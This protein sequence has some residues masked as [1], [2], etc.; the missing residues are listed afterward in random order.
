MT[1]HRTGL[2]RNGLF[3]MV[4]EVYRFLIMWRQDLLRLIWPFV[5]LEFIYLWAR[6]IAFSGPIHD[7]VSLIS[8]G[9]LFLALMTLVPLAARVQ[10]FALAPGAVDSWVQFASLPRNRLW[11]RTFVA[12]CLPLVLAVL[13][14]TGLMILISNP[15]T[16]GVTRTNMSIGV[17]LSIV[18]SVLAVRLILVFPLAFDKGRAVLADAWRLSKG[19]YF[20]LFMLSGFATVPFRLLYRLCDMVGQEV[21]ANTG[22]PVASKLAFYFFAVFLPSTVAI[23][24]QILVL[25]VAVTFVYRDVT[26]R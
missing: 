26:R 2:D 17:G 6:F 1:G 14:G 13:V 7:E 3:S 19:Q 8:F 20:Y 16:L 5:L 15:V 25:I 4:A 10:E 24:G 23:I 9:Y 11:A 12:W 21:W 18:M 22:L